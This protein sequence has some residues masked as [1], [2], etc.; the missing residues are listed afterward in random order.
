M[1]ENIPIWGI[2]DSYG[3]V[4]KAYHSEYKAINECQFDEKIVKLSAHIVEDE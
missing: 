3:L 2:Q 4:I 1:T